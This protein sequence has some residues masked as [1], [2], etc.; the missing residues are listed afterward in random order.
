MKCVHLND[1]IRF[2]SQKIIWQQCAQWIIREQEWEWG[3]NSDQLQ[4]SKW[5]MM[6]ASTKV[7]VEMGKTQQ[8]QRRLRRIMKDSQV[9][10][11][12]NWTRGKSQWWLPYFDWCSWVDSQCHSLGFGWRS[13]GLAQWMKMVIYFVLWVYICVLD[14]DLK[15]YRL[16]TQALESYVLIFIH[17][18]LATYPWTSKPISSS[19]NW[20]K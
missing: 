7:A 13:T 6:M 19:V 1:I 12:R 18:F 5:E 20:E 8:I 15:V 3:N 17:H 9:I 4:R 11:C 10:H 2:V 16:Q 14:L